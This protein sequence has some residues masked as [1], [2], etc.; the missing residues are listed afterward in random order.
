VASVTVRR[1][2]LY[3]VLG[4]THGASSD[5][6]A[7]AFRSHAKRLH[8]DR[9]PGDAHAAEQFKELTLAYQTLIRPG[10]REAYDERHHQP[11]RPAPAPAPPVV[12]T[13]AHDPIFRTPRRARAAIASGIV[14]FALGVFAAVLLA[15]VNTGGTAETVTLWIAT[16]K[17][18]VCGP[19]LV[20]AGAYRLHR[21]ATEQ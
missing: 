4:V 13:S 19:V 8:P 2:D 15:V 12:T 18:L 10:S 11:V 3:E 21:L 14:C 1:G 20:A 5:E 17:L 7:A 9:N 6:I 16:L